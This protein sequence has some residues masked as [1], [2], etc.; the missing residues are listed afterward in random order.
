MPLFNIFI[1]FKVDFSCTRNFTYSKIPLCNYVN[2]A[3]TEANKIV[4]KI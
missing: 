3:E 2:R 1:I 4:L